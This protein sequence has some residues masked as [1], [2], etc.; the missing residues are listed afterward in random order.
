MQHRIIAMLTFVS[1]C[2][3]ILI[4]ASSY[5]DAQ[6]ELYRVARAFS[7]VHKKESG[8]HVK[9]KKKLAKQ[10]EKSI[11]SLD[12]PP[13]PSSIPIVGWMYKNTPMTPTDGRVRSQTGN[14]V[15]RLTDR[16]DSRIERLMT[17]NYL[18]RKHGSYQCIE[19]WK[20]GLG[21]NF[22]N[23]RTQTNPK[24]TSSTSKY[25]LEQMD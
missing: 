6:K 24:K 21:F 18:Q 3:T 16:M 11:I 22:S 17:Y 5:S 7:H 8:K 4:Q 15:A 9:R 19:S 1:M 2:T 12:V 10:E 25:N 13:M 20:G 14:L 23:I